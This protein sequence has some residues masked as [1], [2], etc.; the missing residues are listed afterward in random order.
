MSKGQLNHNF[1]LYRQ[2]LR[3][4]DSGFIGYAIKANHN[5]N[6]LRHLAGLGSGAVVV[7]G[8]ELRMA[9]YAGFD[10]R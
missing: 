9:L 8:N 10:P 1:N 4:L 3:G 5:V 7:S 2:A 6:V